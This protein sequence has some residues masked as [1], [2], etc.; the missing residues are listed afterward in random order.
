[1]NEVYSENYPLEEE[2]V[3]DGVI[4]FFDKKKT[5]LSGL[6]AKYGTDYAGSKVAADIFHD[7]EAILKSNDASTIFNE[8]MKRKE[9]LEENAETLEQL[10]AFYK[11]NSSQQKN[12]QD[13][14]EM[15]DWYTQNYMLQDLSDMGDVISKMNEIVGMEMPFQRMNELANLVFQASNI[16]DKILETKLKRTKRQLESDRDTISKELSE[17]VLADLTDDQK[18]RLQEKADDLMSQYESWL[19]SLTKKTANMDSY[20]TASSTSVRT[21]RSFITQVMNEGTGG[22]IPV[23]RTKKVSII[24]SI[25]VANKKVKTTEDVD[26]VVTAIKQKLLRELEDNDELNLY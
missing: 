4:A 24:D 2:K 14:T 18:S 7:F 3:K 26:R 1:M 23:I 16:K 22:D 9:S 11:E 15:I 5:F 12:Y 17:A 6:K 8:I 10:E 25:P 21:F 20:I 13:A 19:N